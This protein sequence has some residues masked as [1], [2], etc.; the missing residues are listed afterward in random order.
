MGSLGGESEHESL[1]VLGTS[2][3][4]VSIIGVG[5]TSSS[6]AMRDGD[7]FEGRIGRTASGLKAKG[8]LRKLG[9]KKMHVYENGQGAEC[10]GVDM[11]PNAVSDAEIVS[12]KFGN[13]LHSLNA[14]KA[15][16][17]TAFSM[18]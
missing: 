7:D 13:F 10:V 4:Y 8:S 15:P 6:S 3:G 17:R 11:Q 2:K 9:S 1:A 12:G 18:M 16:I 14:L 5:E